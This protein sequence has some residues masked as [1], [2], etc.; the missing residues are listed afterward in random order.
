VTDPDRR[1]LIVHRERLDLI[2]DT[3]RKGG[4]DVRVEPRSGWRNVLEPMVKK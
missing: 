4:C 1:F 3:L 2:V